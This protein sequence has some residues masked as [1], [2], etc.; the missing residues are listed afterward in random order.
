LAKEKRR[1][2]ARPCTFLA[3]W[4]KKVE[5][6]LDE[7]DG[8][9]E[10]EEGSLGGRGKEKLLNRDAEGPAKRSASNRDMT[11]MLTERA[12]LRSTGG[13]E[14]GKKKNLEGKRCV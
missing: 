13:G 1:R 11:E 3:W 8:E 5:A 14:R 9:A 7:G 4:K 10:G 6:R 2:G 12:S